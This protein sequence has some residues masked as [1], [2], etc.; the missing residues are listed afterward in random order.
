MATKLFY[1]KHPASDFDSLDLSKYTSNIRWR[2]DKTEFVVEFKVKPENET[3]L[4]NHEEAMQLVSGQEWYSEP[5][6]FTI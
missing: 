4:L 5:E 1:K 3:S 2:I 6:D